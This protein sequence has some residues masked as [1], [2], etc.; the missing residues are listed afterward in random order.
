MLTVLI[1][2]KFGITYDEFQTQPQY[3]NELIIQ[4]IKVDE[5]REANQNKK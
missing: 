2:E 5:Q 1:C 3:F 4:K